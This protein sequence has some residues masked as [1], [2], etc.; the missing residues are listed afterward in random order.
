MLDHPNLR[1]RL[2]GPNAPAANA[3]RAELIEGYRLMWDMDYP[4]PAAARVHI[5]EQRFSVVA[6]TAHQ[7]PG[8]LGLPWYRSCQL[9]EVT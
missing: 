4:M 3:P 1:C 8:P 9:K 6:G 2:V 5:G 7:V